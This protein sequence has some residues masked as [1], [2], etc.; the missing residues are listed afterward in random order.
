MG[1]IEIVNRIFR[2]PHA[3][4]EIRYVIIDRRQTTTMSTHI[5][6]LLPSPTHDPF[7]CISISQHPS[8]RPLHHQSRQRN[9]INIYRYRRKLKYTQKDDSSR[10]STIGSASARNN[11]ARSDACRPESQSTKSAIGSAIDREPMD[12]IER[13]RYYEFEHIIPGSL[14]EDR[15]HPVCER[16]HAPD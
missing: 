7:Y 8:L 1:L 14:C 10:S 6:Q 16:K 2:K 5:A 4:V 13:L 9:A 3:I 11:S 12:D 15:H